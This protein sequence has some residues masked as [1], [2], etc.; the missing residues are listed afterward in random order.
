MRE[1]QS[2]GLAKRESSQA[3]RRSGRPLDRASAEVAE[4][5]IGQRSEWPSAGVVEG[6]SQRE[7]VKIFNPENWCTD[8]A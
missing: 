5:R 4:G 8:E 2:D 3:P 1:K 7:H 6:Q